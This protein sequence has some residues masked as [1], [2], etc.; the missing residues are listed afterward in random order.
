MYS[1]WGICVRPLPKAHGTYNDDLKV[2]ITDLAV[3]V[4]C[5]VGYQSSP[6]VYIPMHYNMGTEKH[7]LVFT[8]YTHWHMMDLWWIALYR[9]FKV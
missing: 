7:V 8:L 1:K 2:L 4:Y 3:V 6:K 9:F 5:H